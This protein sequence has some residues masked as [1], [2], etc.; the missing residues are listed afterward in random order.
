MSLSVRSLTA[1]GS[2][3]RT[4]HWGAA[5]CTTAGACALAGLS[6]SPA[7]HPANIKTATIMDNL[8]TAVSPRV[9][10]LEFNTPIA[11]AGVHLNSPILMEINTTQE[12]KVWNRSVFE[13]ID[14]VLTNKDAG[15][16][17]FIV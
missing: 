1:L 6:G 2:A 10:C 13:V 5:T 8:R 11:H 4:S 15:V 14:H 3:T 17:G 16:M 9:N 12:E 7:P